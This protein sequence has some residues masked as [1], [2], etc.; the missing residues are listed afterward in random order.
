MKKGGLSQKI[1]IN[2]RFL[3]QSITGVQRYAHEVVKALDSMIDSGEID[4]SHYQLQ[5][6]APGKGI[7][8]DLG[9]KHIH[10]QQIGKPTG[11]LWEQTVLPAGSRDGLL[12]CPGNTAPAISLLSGQK[13][14]VT[15]HD[16]S[17]LYFPDA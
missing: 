5:I 4:K 8:Y 2:G 11:H 10:L 7:K 17:Y 3:T 6:L 1:Y 12:F 13:T 16:L 9:L 14:V 15:V